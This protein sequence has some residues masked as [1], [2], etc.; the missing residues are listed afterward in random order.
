LNTKLRCLLLDDELPGL[1]YLRLMCEQIAHVEVVKTFNNPLQ[2]LAEVKKLDYDICILDI[3]M[4]GLNGIDVA[5]ALHGKPVIFT[6]AHKEYAPEAFDLEAIDYIQKPIKKERLERALNKALALL[7]QTEQD[8]KFIPVNTTKGKALLFIYQ[9][10]YITTSAGDKRDKIITL[11]SGEEVTV[12][13]LSFDDLLQQLPADQFCRIN[14]K[15]IISL[16]SVRFFLHD[17]ITTKLTTSNGTEKILTLSDRYRQ[18]FT[19]KV[20]R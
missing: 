11:E 4:P 19:D 3:E 2:L 15:E 9:I 10:L 6:T 5:H 20:K 8:R 7:R 1:A 14:K 17:T 16:K 12:K 18:E 13:N